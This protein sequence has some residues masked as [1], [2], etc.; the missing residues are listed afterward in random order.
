M[1]SGF[2]KELQLQAKGEWAPFSALSGQET[3]KQNAL[4]DLKDIEHTISIA[5][6]L[7]Q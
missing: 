2:S 3:K 4:A 1:K 6:T 5:P 7:G